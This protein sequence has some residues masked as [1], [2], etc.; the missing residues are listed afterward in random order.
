[1]KFLAR[2]TPTEAPTPAVPPTPTPTDAAM[3]PALMAA[4]F[5]ASMIT[6][7]NAES[8]LVC[9]YALVMVWMKLAASAPAPLTAIPA[10]PP[11]PTASDAAAV[12]T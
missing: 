7:S 4:A 9:A 3:T 2:A 12:K 1:M 6:S 5:C 10:V 8:T 11:I